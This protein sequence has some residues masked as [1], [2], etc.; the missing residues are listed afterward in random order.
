[1]TT[2]FHDPAEPKTPLGVYRLLA[3]TAGI[4]VSPLCLG[5]MSL[6]NQWDGFMGG[7]GLNQEESEKM[8][9]TFYEAGGNFIDVANGY[10]G[11]SGHNELC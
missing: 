1:M 8:L 2:L 5:A 10:Q 4:R 6:G 9:D 3:P 7:K 11:E